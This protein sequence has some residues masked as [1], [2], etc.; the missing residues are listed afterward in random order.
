[1]FN[2]CQ[3]FVDPVGFIGGAVLNRGHEFLDRAELLIVLD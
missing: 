2:R 1:M 3:E